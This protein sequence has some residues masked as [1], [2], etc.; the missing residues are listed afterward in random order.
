[1]LKV[2]LSL[3]NS[4]VAVTVKVYLPF[5]RVEGMYTTPNLSTVVPSGAPEIVK[6]TGRVPEKSSFITVSTTVIALILTFF[7]NSTI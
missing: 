1:M 6:L 3:P 7:P 5:L 2:T 4:F